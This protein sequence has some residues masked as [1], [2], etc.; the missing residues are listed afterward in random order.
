[1][2]LPFTTW[3]PVHG[4]SRPSGWKMQQRYFC[5][6]E[7]WHVAFDSLPALKNGYRQG[8]SA[9]S[10]IL[11]TLALERRTTACT[12][13]GAHGANQCWDYERHLRGASRNDHAN[14]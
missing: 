3:G 9:N 13:G 7:I 5:G 8:V 11:L 1:M 12:I 14:I 2:C 4:A 10:K 6:E